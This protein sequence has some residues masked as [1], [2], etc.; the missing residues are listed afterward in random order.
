[1]SFIYAIV[2]EYDLKTYS[3]YYKSKFTGVKKMKRVVTGVNMQK[4]EESC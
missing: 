4:R 2:I 3:N 1:M